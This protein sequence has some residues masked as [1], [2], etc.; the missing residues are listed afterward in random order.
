MRHTGYNIALYHYFI[1]KDTERRQLY[2][3]CWG[4]VEHEVVRILITIISS[5]L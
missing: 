4:C 5:N 1:K 3:V 2:V